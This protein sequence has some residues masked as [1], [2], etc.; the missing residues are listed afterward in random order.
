M[1]D[2]KLPERRTRGYYKFSKKYPSRLGSDYVIGESRK[3]K[4]KERARKILLA[5]L[6]VCAFI[7]VY[8]FSAFIYDLTARPLPEK[9]ADE[10]PIITADN[11]GT[12]RAIYIENE[13]TADVSDFTDA[14]R[15]AKK[16]GFNAV[17]LDFK[18][19]DGYLAYKSSVSKY[20]GTAKII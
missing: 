4:K 15:E 11:I 10:T 7:G 13:K 3:V 14:L 18:T 17:M 12:L 19:R 2:N 8:I 9:P 5:V 20:S 6:S 16:N 1:K